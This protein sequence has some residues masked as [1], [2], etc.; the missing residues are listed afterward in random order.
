MDFINPETGIFSNMRS[1]LADD[2]VDMPWRR[3]FLM[4]MPWQ[5]V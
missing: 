2:R 1:V 5:G 3:I 4:T